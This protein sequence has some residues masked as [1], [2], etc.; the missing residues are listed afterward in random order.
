VRN[1]IYKHVKESKLLRLIGHVEMEKKIE[2]TIKVITQRKGS[3]E[4]G[5]DIPIE[6]DE[7]ALKKYVDFVI[8]EIKKEH[9]KNKRLFIGIL[10]NYF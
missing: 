10:L 5:T 1:S 6:F 9:V 3:L 2:K 8:R 4:R 7:T